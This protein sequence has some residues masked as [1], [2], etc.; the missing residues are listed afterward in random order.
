M[1]FSRLLMTIG[2]PLR[3]DIID[4]WP[5]IHEV[6][7]LGPVLSAQLPKVSSSRSWTLQARD[8][9]RFDSSSI[10]MDLAHRS[11]AIMRMATESFGEMR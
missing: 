8:A 4:P 9:I 11:Y 6:S 5:T 10:L 2:Q 7:Q 1:S 3:E